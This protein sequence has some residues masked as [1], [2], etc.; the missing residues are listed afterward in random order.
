MIAVGQGNCSIE[1]HG[2]VFKAV[3]IDIAMKDFD[4]LKEKSGD[5]QQDVLAGRAEAVAYSRMG[6]ILTLGGR[7]E[8]ARPGLPDA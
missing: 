2:I 6:E 4:K 3:R 5:K 8:E 7:I 1:A